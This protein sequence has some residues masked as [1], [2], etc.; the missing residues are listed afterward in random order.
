M[1]RLLLAYSLLVSM[2]LC[3]PNL[4][5]NTE[6]VVTLITRKSIDRLI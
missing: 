2:F 4:R 1:K 3:L 6:Q 5:K